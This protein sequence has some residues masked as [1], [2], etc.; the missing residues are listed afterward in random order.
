M[1]GIIYMIHQIVYEAV[2]KKAGTNPPN[3]YIGNVEMAAGIGLVL[4]EIGK[5]MDFGSISTPQEIKESFLEL[6]SD[7]GK[8]KLSD[9]AKIICGRVEKYKVK[10]MVNENMEDLEILVKCT[11]L[12]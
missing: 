5:E 6:I 1:E 10:A 12:N 9:T 2:K 8:D 11:C 4:K 3:E 7:Y